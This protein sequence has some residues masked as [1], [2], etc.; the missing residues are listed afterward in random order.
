[1]NDNGRKTNMCST[2]TCV[3]EYGDMKE[4]RGRRDEI[5]SAAGNQ[6]S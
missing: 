2:C 5:A 4:Y 1:M 6:K 3:H